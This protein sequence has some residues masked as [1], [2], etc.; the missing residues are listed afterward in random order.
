MRFV[1]SVNDFLGGITVGAGL[2]LGWT[3]AAW[4]VN[5]ITAKL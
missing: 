5:R 2:G 1:A 3:A 4:L